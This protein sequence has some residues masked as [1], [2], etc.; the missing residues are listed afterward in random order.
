MACLGKWQR[1]GCGPP[2][3]FVVRTRSVTGHWAAAP[4]PPF[5]SDELEK[6]LAIVLATSQQI[7]RSDTRMR[8]YMDFI[9]RW[10]VGG[11]LG[12]LQGRVVRGQHQVACRRLFRA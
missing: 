3:L 8:H 2:L 11:G 4:S 12:R 6:V 5:G 10:V 9:I 7:P 1:A